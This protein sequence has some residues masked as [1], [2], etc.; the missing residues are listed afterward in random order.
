MASINGLSVKK[1][2][3]FRGHEGEP[4]TQC[5]VYYNGKNVGFFS[6]ADWGGEDT[7]RVSK[8]VEELFKDYKSYSGG[9][10]F[11]GISSAI[12]DVLALH[13]IEKEYKKAI[14]KT[15]LAGL[16][17]VKIDEYRHASLV[18]NKLLC[19]MPI[20][21]LVEKV[22]NTFPKYKDFDIS[23]FKLYKSIEDFNITT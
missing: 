9:Y 2:V 17:L 22:K 13:D 11:T 15:E 3:E 7:V 23:A 18:V 21:E 10:L 5:D 6:M 1:I 14:K 8:D 16:L 19:S 4:L 20:E 12:Y